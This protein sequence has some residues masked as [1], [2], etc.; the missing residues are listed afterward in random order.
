VHSLDRVDRAGY[1][2][3]G[4]VGDHHPG[5]DAARR[6]NDA[7]VDDHAYVDADDHA[8][9]HDVARDHATDDHAA[10]HDLAAGHEYVFSG[11]HPSGSRHP[12]AGGLSRCGRP[13]SGVR[14]LAR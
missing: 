13:R 3:A 10:G 4:D 11:Q 9:G 14:V 2:T 5:H 6:G 12:A 7:V 1:C 8:A